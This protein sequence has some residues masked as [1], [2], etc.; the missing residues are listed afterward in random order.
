VKVVVT[1]RS[2]YVQDTNYGERE[3]KNKVGSGGK[4]KEL[5]APTKELERSHAEL[6]QFA[7]AVSRG[8]QEPLSMVASYTQLLAQR[9][10]GKLD[11]ETDELITSILEGVTW[12]QKLISG[13]R[14]YSS[15]TREGKSF[16]PTDCEVVLDRT[17]T[18]RKVKIEQSDAVITHDILPTVMADASQLIQ[19][20]GKLIGNAM[21]YRNGVSPRIHISAESKGNEWIFSV[22]DNGIGIAREYHQHIFVIFQRLHTREQYPGNGI[23]LAICKRIV[24]RHGGHIWVESEPGKGSTFYF[25]IPL[26]VGN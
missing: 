11:A 24:E 13:L 23:G 21:K 20:L 17:L 12:M 25:T 3:K 16:Q 22:H 5:Q 19:L 10:Q 18:N 4:E 1:I 26:K 2:I 7:Y 9:Y 14:G 15:V 8:L 6:E